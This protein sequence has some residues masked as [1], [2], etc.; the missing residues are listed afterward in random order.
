MYIYISQWTVCS[1]KNFDRHL[2]RLIVIVSLH[3]S[4]A[5]V[6][7]CLLRSLRF[8]ACWIHFWH[9]TVVFLNV[10]N[11]NNSASIGCIMHIVH[12]SLLNDN[13]ENSF[14]SHLSCTYRNHTRKCHFCALYFS[15]VNSQSNYLQ[16][17]VGGNVNVYSI[18]YLLFKILIQGVW[19]QRA[20]FD[21]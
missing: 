16:R 9:D 8:N 4:H 2:N 6:C 18:I 21:T 20:R 14:G 15:L 5:F 11:N 17:A 7:L 13:I 19:Y 1:Q 3:C 10:I 12:N